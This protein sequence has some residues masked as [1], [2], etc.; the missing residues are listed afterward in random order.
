MLNTGNMRALKLVPLI[1]VIAGLKTGED[2]VYFY[3]RLVPDGVR[4]VSYHSPA[5]PELVL[6]DRDVNEFL[7]ELRVPDDG[8]ESTGASGQPKEGKPCQLGSSPEVK[9]GS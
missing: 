1:R 9:L 7:S 3:N 8:A 5:E 2:A 4:W 6:V